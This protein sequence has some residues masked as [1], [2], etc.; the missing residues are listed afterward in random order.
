MVSVRST[1]NDINN[2]N[3][4]RALALTPVFD[5]RMPKDKLELLNWPHLRNLTLVVPFSP[6]Q[7]QH[8]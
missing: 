4:L 1:L 6:E 2:F 3:N 7:K 8:A 5:Y